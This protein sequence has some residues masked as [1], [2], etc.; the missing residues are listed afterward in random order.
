MDRKSLGNLVSQRI[1]LSN[2]TVDMFF[3]KDRFDTY[4][5]PDKHEQKSKAASRGK[6]IDDPMK[7]GD[8][9]KSLS[10]ISNRQESHRSMVYIGHKCICLYLFVFGL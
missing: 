7:A 1:R 5:S 10:V 4:T 8:R 9:E 2:S 3:S 6:P